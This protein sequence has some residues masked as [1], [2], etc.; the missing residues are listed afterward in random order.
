MIGGNVEDV[1]GV[2]Q[3]EYRDGMSQGEVVSLGSKALTR[4]TGESTPLDSKSLEVCVLYRERTGRKFRRLSAEE[5][6]VMLD[7]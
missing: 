7:A 6:Q 1:Q 2:L 3:D 4:G 5:V